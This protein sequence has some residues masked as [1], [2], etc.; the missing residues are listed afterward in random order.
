MTRRFHILLLALLLTSA[1]TASEPPIAEALIVEGNR[2]VR[3]RRKSGF[4]LARYLMA[5]RGT[6]YT[7]YTLI[8]MS[9]YNALNNPPYRYNLPALAMAGQEEV[10]PVSDEIMKLA[11]KNGWSKE[12][13]ARFTLALVSS[14]P[15]NEDNQTSMVEFYRHAT[16]TLKDGGGD[17]ED[18]TILYC[19]LLRNLG[20][21]PVMIVTPGH[22]GVGVD[23]A[24]SGSRLRY[25][26]RNYYYAET[27]GDGFEIGQMPPGVS[28]HGAKVAAINAETAGVQQTRPTPRQ[29]EPRVQPNQQPNRQPDRQPQQR[30]TA[31]PQRQTQQMDVTGLLIIILL[32]VLAVGIIFFFRIHGYRSAKEIDPAPKRRRL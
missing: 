31:R 22:I 32:N 26:N 3:D 10:K 14:L 30:R 6:E 1:A 9:G 29:P 16:E 7:F 19:A 13:T 12:E 17:C 4:S 15:Y 5:F 27:T 25:R 24:F 18:T 28:L 23:G 2:Q 11:R 20:F 8:S 21:D